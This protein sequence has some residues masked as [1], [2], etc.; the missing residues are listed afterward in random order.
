[1]VPNSGFSIG[2]LDQQVTPSNNDKEDA[3]DLYHKLE[4]EILPMYYDNHSEW[5]KRMKSAITL[6]AYFNTNRAIEEYLSK[7]WKK[8]SEE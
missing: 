8:T 5:L 4:H 1:M 7:A 2:P 3:Q 6:G